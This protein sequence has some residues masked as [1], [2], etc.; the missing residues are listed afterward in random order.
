[1][2][3]NIL[4][5]FVTLGILGLVL[6][7]S[8]TPATIGSTQT[9]TVQAHSQLPPYNGPKASV[10]VSEF[11]C[12]AAKCIHRIGRGMADALISSLVMSNRFE[13][14]ESSGNLGVLQSELNVTGES[15]AFQGS[16]IAI[17]AAVTAF[18]PNA[19]GAGG[20]G[21][22]AP[23][24]FI[25]AV[26]ASKKEAYVAIDLR[27]VDIRTR[28]VI[29]VSKI[30]GLASRFGGGIFGGGVLGGVAIAG[31]QNT[32]M[33]KAIADLIDNVVLDI[34]NKVP[35]SYYSNSRP[36]NAPA[37]PQAVQPVEITP[38]PAQTTQL[39]P[40]DDVS[41]VGVIPSV[42]S[43]DGGVFDVT[44]SP[45]DANGE[46]ITGGV[47][48]SNFSF[49]N[50]SITKAS[51]P[52]VATAFGVADPTKV[53]IITT[54]SN[55]RVSL[56]LD[57]DSSGSMDDNDPQKL[58]VNAGKQ[59]VDLLASNDQA[60]IVDFSARIR[61]LQGFTSDKN[62]LK[63]AIDRVGNSGG[64]SLYDSLL[65]VLKLFRDSGAVTNPVIVVLSDGEDTDSAS[66][67]NDVINQ[68]TLQSTP[69]FPI[70]L[71]T[72]IDFSELQNLAGQTN[73][74][75]GEAN[76]AEDLQKVFEA[77]GVGLTQGRIKVVGEGRF[78]P[79]LTSAGEYIFSGELVTTLG[80]QSVPTPFSFRVNV[81]Q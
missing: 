42:F 48:L 8:C 43:L 7:A 51:D 55:E 69:I 21:I 78:N 36:V 34:V 4:R 18:E 14:L 5:F 26:G 66:T 37:A 59:I 38:P 56:V 12:K 32:P 47:T 41:L 73:G 53:E 74:T 17:L 10:V 80:G 13:V 63:A 58:R 60:A 57:F 54:S 15:S 68:A 3:K 1:M 35:A 40:V 28:Q 27:L 79:A 49:R 61:L 70:S 75:F 81:T 33:E 77:I 16:D 45:K 6:L 71:G 67:V 9:S 65:A 39:L 30:E 19:A 23:L 46:L 22:A 76:K 62:A 44:V 25:G 50:I 24:P 31:Y 72:N 11:E 52:N 2:N 29:A 20:V 64:T